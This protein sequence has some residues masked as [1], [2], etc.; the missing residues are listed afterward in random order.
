M[1][2]AVMIWVSNNPIGVESHLWRLARVDECDTQDDG[3][4][5]NDNGDVNGDDNGDCE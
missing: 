3:D 1:R 5:A 4:N 2:M